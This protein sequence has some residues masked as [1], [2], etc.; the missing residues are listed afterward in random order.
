MRNIEGELQKLSI[1]SFK[2]VFF[3]PNKPPYPTT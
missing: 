1:K 3:D 2:N